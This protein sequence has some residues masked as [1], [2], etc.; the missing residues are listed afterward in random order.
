MD[1]RTIQLQDTSSSHFQSTPSVGIY[2]FYVLRAQHVIY[3]RRVYI[4]LRRVDP[5]VWHLTLFVLGAL[6]ASAWV[7]M[8]QASQLA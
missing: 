2:S 4:L 5:F 3:A 1:I 6:G 7:S 8:L